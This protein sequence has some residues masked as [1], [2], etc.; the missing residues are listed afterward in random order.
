LKGEGYTEKADIFSAGCL[1]Y[2]LLTGKN[3]FEGKD[4]DEVLNA[5]RECNL[6][7]VFSQFSKTNLSK[8]CI[9]LLKLMLETDQKIR[10]SAS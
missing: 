8:K 3:I 6:E 1:L 10:L 2:N 4:L 5:N 9:D 7:N